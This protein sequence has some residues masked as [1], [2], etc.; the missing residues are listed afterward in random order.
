MSP[1]RFYYSTHSNVP[2]ITIS[3]LS[4]FSVDLEDIVRLF[5][6]ANKYWVLNNCIQGT[7]RSYMSLTIFLLH[8]QR[9]G[10]AMSQSA[11][12]TL[13]WVF[14]LLTRPGYQCFE[15]SLFLFLLMVKIAKPSTTYL[16]DQVDISMNKYFIPTF[17]IKSKEFCCNLR[18]PGVSSFSLF[19]S[20]H[21]G[22]FY[23]FC[24]LIFFR[25]IAD[26]HNTEMFISIIWI[27][28]LVVVMAMGA[29]RRISRPYIWLR[30]FCTWV[31]K[32]GDWFS[33]N[34]LLLCLFSFI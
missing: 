29:R 32:F 22:T 3:Y 5:C 18:R 1:Y 7:K 12:R 15:V 25:A 16:I 19:C 8:A 2:S 26:S 13:Y 11:W 31:L 30:Y 24:S 6:F 33:T 27:Y 9:R 34:K 4:V 14:K 20:R 21:Q 10:V 23:N 28:I 17:S